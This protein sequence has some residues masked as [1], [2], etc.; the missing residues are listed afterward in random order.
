MQIKISLLAISA[1]S[2]FVLPS[3]VVPQYSGATPA[4]ASPS[5]NSPVVNTSIRVLP[6]GYRTVYVSGSPYYY[7]GN[8]W[9]RRYNNRYISCP[10]PQAYRGN[11]GYSQKLIKPTSYSQPVSR[12]RTTSLVGNKYYSSASPQY[13]QQ[14]GNNHSSRKSYQTKPKPKPTQY[15]NRT[16]PNRNKVSP[17]QKQKK[18]YSQQNPK[19]KSQVKPPA[20]SS[21]KDT[22]VK[23]QTPKS[24]RSVPVSTGK[25]RS[26]E[27]QVKQTLLKMKSR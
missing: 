23:V 4:Y 7:H 24:S 10:R 22:S 27:D 26:K 8:S 17:P 13:Y 19:Q 15:N 2:L 11:I 6:Q 21:R 12:Y 14:Q 25:Q 5:Y 3:C 1:L 9:Y 16:E 20:S 18:T